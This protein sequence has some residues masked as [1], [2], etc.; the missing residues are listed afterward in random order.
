MIPPFDTSGNLPPGIHSAEWTE[1]EARFGTTPRRRALLTGLRAALDALALA[2]CRT[3]YIDGS[4]VTSKSTPGDFDACWDVTG[5]DPSRLDPILLTF[6]NGRAAQ[7]ARFGGE[8]FPAQLPE[9]LSGRTFLEFFQT[10]RRTGS[11]K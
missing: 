8:L 2:N 4:F 7:K 11:P 10:D 6:D 5:V 9:G 3:V 1:V